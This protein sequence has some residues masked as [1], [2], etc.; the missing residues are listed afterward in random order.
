MVELKEIKR[1]RLHKD[2]LFL[3]CLLDNVKYNGKYLKIYDNFGYDE[4]FIVSCNDIKVNYYNISD[5][6]GK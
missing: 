4:L 1:N 3:I 6:I 5:Y 2:I